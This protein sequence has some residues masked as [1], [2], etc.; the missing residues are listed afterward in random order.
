MKDIRDEI[1]KKIKHQPV[2]ANIIADDEGIIAGSVAARKEAEH[3]G[4]KIIQWLDNAEPVKK[5][6]TIAS[7]FGTPKQ[8][9]SAEEV[10][11][12][13][14]AKP[15]GIATAAKKFVDKCGNRLQIVSG[16]W[17]KMPLPLKDTI[18]AA[19]AAGGAAIRI[20]DSP[21]VYLDKNYIKIFGGIAATLIATESLN[22]QKRVLQIHGNFKDIAIEACEAA[23]NGADIIFIDTGNPNDVIKVTKILKEKGLRQLVT[24]VF[25]G[26]IRLKDLD[27]LMALDID[28]L[29]VGRS[30]VDAP[31][32]DMR[33]EIV[34]GCKYNVQKI[35]TEGER[36]AET[37]SHVSRNCI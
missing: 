20:S 13:H 1:F 22:D 12:G 7:F 19:V 32:L 37:C 2:T 23:E 16:S 15:S 31:L 8:V 28:C 17:K 3:L 9:V 33:M 25:A 18:R 6:D 34:S 14:L 11:M 5:G 10:V 27:L 26:G 36:H 21:F 24:I 4:L 29:D 30:I 35:Y